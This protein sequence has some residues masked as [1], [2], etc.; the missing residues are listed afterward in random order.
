MAMVKVLNVSVV[1]WPK[2]FQRP[3][4]TERRI[5]KQDKTGNIASLILRKDRLQPPAPGEARIAVKAVGLNFADVFTTLGL[6]AAAPKTEVIPGLEFSGVV[7][8]L[9]PDVPDRDGSETATTS[10]ST[11]GLKVGDR[12]MGVTRFGAFADKLNAQV[13]LLQTIPPG[14]SL[15]HGAAFLVQ[16]LTAMYGLRNQGNLRRRQTV[17]IHSAAGGCGQFAMDICHAFGATPIATVG[18]PAKIDYLLARYP[19]LKPEQ[20]IVRDASR[21]RLGTSA[22]L[23]NVVRQD[24]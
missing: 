8:E 23:S 15:Q 3:D 11:N 1:N 24:S 2:G 10:Q 18:T 19:W 22:G 21:Y 16:G 13:H 17:L 20:I 12:V 14:W 5:W 6:Y 9:G 4:M 7:E